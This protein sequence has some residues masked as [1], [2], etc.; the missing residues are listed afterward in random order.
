MTDI[1]DFYLFI[2][3][4]SSSSFLFFSPETNTLI[5]V[6]H[7]YELAI[8]QLV[9]RRTVEKTDDNLTSLGH[10]FESGSRDF[11]SPRFQTLNTYL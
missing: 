8:A 9:E 6:R 5:I 11:F 7:W 2:Y 10:W 4:F 1:L 3:L